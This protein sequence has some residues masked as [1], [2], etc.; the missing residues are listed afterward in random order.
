MVFGLWFPLQPPK[1]KPFEHWYRGE[2]SRNG[3]VGELRVGKRMEMLKIANY[4]HTLKTKV[5]DTRIPILSAVGDGR[6]RR[7][8]AG[9][10][11]GIGTWEL[12]RGSLYLDEE[13][14]MEVARVF[15]EG[16]L[17]GG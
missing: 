3:G 11:S 9:S 17:E 2:V 5:L 7:K 10:V 4:G 16:P 6:R 8:R 15:D 13:R 1:E 12:D 14:A